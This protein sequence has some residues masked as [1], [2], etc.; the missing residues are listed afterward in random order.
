[1]SLSVTQG[2]KVLREVASAL[3]IEEEQIAASWHVM[4]RCGNMS[5]S[6][7]LVVLDHVVR[8]KRFQCGKKFCIGITFAPGL[9][10]QTVLMRFTS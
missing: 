7:N 2:P 10:V 6:S 5:G 3:G 8:E 4:R 9:C 1:M